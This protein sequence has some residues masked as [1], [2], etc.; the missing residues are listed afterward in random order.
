MAGRKVIAITDRQFDVLKILWEHGPATVRELIE[1]LPSRDRLPYTTVLG[2]L[3]TMEKAGLLVHAKENQTH[4]YRP[5]LSQGEATRHLLADF[6]G[7]FFRGSAAELVLG[8]VDAEQLSPDD[9]REIEAKLNPEAE[10][11]ASRPSQEE[12]RRPTRRRRSSP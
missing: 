8:L 5:T 12:P 1:R 2:L 3:Q 4:R 9:L 6:L 7:R 10:R 11:G